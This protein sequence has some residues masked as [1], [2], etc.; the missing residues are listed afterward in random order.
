M[1]QS[2]PTAPIE[3]DLVDCALFWST[4]HSLKGSSSR[5]SLA[6]SL[7]AVRILV[8]LGI[9]SPSAEL[10]SRKA[11]EVRIRDFFKVP[12]TKLKESKSPTRIDMILG[13]DS[14]SPEL[15]A[16]WSSE[17]SSLIEGRLYAK[18]RDNYE[19][20]LASASHKAQMLSLLKRLIKLTGIPLQLGE[21]QES[22]EF[23]DIA[24]FIRTILALKLN[25]IQRPSKLR[26]VSALATDS[27]FKGFEPLTKSEL[28]TVF[29]NAALTPKK[30]ADMNREQ[31]EIFEKL[32]VTSAEIDEIGLRS[33]EAW[34][35]Y[36]ARIKSICL[37]DA[38]D[39]SSSDPL[40]AFEG[41]FVCDPEILVNEAET[42][43][44][45]LETLQSIF[46]EVDIEYN[47]AQLTKQSGMDK[48]A[49]EKLLKQ[50]EKLNYLASRKEGSKKFYSLLN[51]EPPER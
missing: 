10:R 46:I 5:D 42:D 40:L 11:G 47:S 38:K 18:I 1:D 7:E 33:G 24:S 25:R 41:Y 50:G 44:E 43:D 32:A 15:R 21:V 23:L 29:G 6:K 36:I 8:S 27:A 3:S 22:A 35:D 4:K 26:K 14:S 12:F 48:A 51:A 45:I 31:A 17:K 37:E 16:Y 20:A 9:E 49:L 2:L 19:K 13:I 30:A 39:R 34:T 28:K